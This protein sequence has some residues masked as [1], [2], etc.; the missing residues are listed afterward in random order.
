M[1]NEIHFEKKYHWIHADTFEGSEYELIKS[2]IHYEY[3]IGFHNHSFYELNIVLNGS[4]TH[5]IEQ[6]SCEA[7]PGSV[8]VIPPNVKHGYINSGHLNVYHMLIH[9]NFL[10]SYFKEFKN[11]LG[12]SLLFDIEPYLRAQYTENIHLMLSQSELNTVIQDIET[13]K[14][15]ET[16]SEGDI[17]TNAI[18]KKILA[19]LCMLI[20]R[21]YG[22][23]EFHL[24]TSKE[25]RGITS[26]LN[27]IHQ[28]FN[29][30]ITVDDLANQLNMSRSTF[31]RHFTKICGCSP[32]HYL[33]QYRLK[34]AAEYLQ[35]SDKTM[36]E[37][38]QLCGFYDA[39]HL[40]K[41]LHTGK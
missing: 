15:C 24:Q 8:F 1:N 19:F 35:D 36:T 34:K 25:L 5:F 32:H 22:G 29:E 40:R 27:Y 16:M 21:Q 11:T 17:Y 4:G 10:D 41:C 38:A 9:Q 23:E 39:S 6:M 33:M 14:A 3:S 7:K 12:F 20:T 30:G 13:I 28:N 37:I 31:L 2:F 18:A 26:C